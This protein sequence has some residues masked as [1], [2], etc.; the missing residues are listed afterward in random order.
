M[1]KFIRNRSRCIRNEIKNKNSTKKINLQNGAGCLEGSVSPSKVE[2]N[3]IN[4]RDYETSA[5]FGG[6]IKAFYTSKAT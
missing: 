1:Q 6:R 3:R 4:K 2:T 5:R